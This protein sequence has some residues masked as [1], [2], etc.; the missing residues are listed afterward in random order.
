MSTKTIT[1][2]DGCG[3]TLSGV[4]YRKIVVF[5]SHGDKWCGDHDLHKD[6]CLDCASNLLTT[7]EKLAAEKQEVSK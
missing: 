2:C 5:A 3:C 1:I 6:L 7:L 4:K